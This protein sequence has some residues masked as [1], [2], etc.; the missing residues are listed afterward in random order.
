M[1]EAFVALQPQLLAK[2]ALFIGNE[3]L[4]HLT[5]QPIHQCGVDGRRLRL[6]CNQRQDFVHALGD[7]GRQ[8]VAGLD[9]YGLLN[10]ALPFGDELNQLAVDPVDRR[11][12]FL[13]CHCRLLGHK[14]SIEQPERL[15]N[16]WRRT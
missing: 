11:A 12:N 5:P 14:R 9:G 3:P 16:V 1:T 4:H 6:V 8:T 15:A 13:Y 10:P 2:G 7:Q